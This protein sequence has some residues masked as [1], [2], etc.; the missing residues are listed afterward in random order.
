MWEKWFAWYPIKINNSWA[1]LET[2][3]RQFWYR[4]SDKPNDTGYNYRVY[5]SNG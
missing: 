1:W 3:E 4:I 2:V 5:N